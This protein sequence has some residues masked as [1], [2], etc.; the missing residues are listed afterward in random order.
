L[1]SL[2][3]SMTAA[4]RWCPAGPFFLFLSGDGDEGSAVQD[5]DQKARAGVIRRRAGTAMGAGALAAIKE[6]EGEGERPRSVH[7]G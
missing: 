1:R 3:A 2:T 6:G 5:A 7:V 4:R